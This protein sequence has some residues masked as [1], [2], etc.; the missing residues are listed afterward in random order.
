MELAVNSRRISVSIAQ[1]TLNIG[2]VKAV[3]FLSEMEKLGIVSPY[4]DKR[5]RE[6]LI[7]PEEWKIMLS[8]FDN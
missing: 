2:Y 3:R 6:V 1:R 5:P 4:N 8:K 7:S